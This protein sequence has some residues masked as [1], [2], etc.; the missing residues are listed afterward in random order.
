MK[1]IESFRD[2]ICSLAV[3]AIIALIVFGILVGYFA[4]EKLGIKLFSWGDFE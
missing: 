4:S 3:I 1:L 2:L